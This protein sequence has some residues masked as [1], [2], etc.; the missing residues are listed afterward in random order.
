MKPSQI[1]EII[2]GII[3]EMSVTGGSAS[4]SSG[5][6]EQ[7]ATPYAFKNKKRLP[8]IRKPLR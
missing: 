8:I 1:K 5:T 2:R 6:G 4:F 7:Y 3:K